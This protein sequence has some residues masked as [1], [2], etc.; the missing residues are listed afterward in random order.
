MEEGENFD[1]DMDW[2]NEVNYNIPGAFKHNETRWSSMFTMVKRYIQLRPYINGNM[3][4]F[5]RVVAKGTEN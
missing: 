3:D 5:V 2:E 4:D 1:E